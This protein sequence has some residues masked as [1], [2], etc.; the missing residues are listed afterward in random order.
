MIPTINPAPH[1]LFPSPALPPSDLLLGTGAVAPWECPEVTGIA[2]Q[3]PRA[4]FT[5]FDSAPSALRA[6]RAGSAWWQS[7]DGTW[8][9]RLAPD[10][11]TAAKWLAGDDA[12]APPESS[13]DVPGNWEMQ[14]YG[15]PHYTNMQMPFAEEPPH[16]IGRASGRE[17]V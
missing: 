4:T 3:P 2:K 8:S 13:I 11:R 9:F 7:L 17:R 12:D 16:E 14:G 5:S 6:D 1:V 15:R 10:P